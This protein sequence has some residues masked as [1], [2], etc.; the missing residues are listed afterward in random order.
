MNSW[1]HSLRSRLPGGLLLFDLVQSAAD[2]RYGAR[3]A[4]IRMKHQLRIYFCG[5][6]S[7]ERNR[8]VA[9]LRPPYPALFHLSPSV[10]AE[11]I[12]RQGLLPKRG[13]VW[14]TDWT[15]PRW[16][17]R[18]GFKTAVCFR[19]DTERLVSAGHRVAIREH[20][21]EFTTDFVPPDCLCALPGSDT[22]PAE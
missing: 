16:T 10:N 21:H 15:N 12:L 7:A 9:E 4:R 14:L 1:L 5:C 11:S 2:R 19:I 17:A 22:I 13:L 3:I 20:S 6:R 8:A 18:F